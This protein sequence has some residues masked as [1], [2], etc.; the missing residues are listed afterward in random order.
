[1]SADHT[2]RFRCLIAAY[3]AG[4]RDAMRPLLAADMVGYV[5]NAKGG[6]DEVRGASAYLARVPSGDDA[7]F[8]AEA[9][10]VVAVSPSQVL[11]MVAIKA[12]R[13]GKSLHNHAG[14]LV[15]Y[16]SAGL[17]DEVWM[18]DAQP[19]YSDEFWS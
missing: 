19:A 2:E 10:Q 15:R 7:T 12:E 8:S 18:V 9:T 16:D 6:V 4:D 5:T 13:N 17:I 14:F 11:A 3:D 1:V